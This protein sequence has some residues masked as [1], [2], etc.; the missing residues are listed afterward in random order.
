MPAQA[1]G[2]RSSEGRFEKL[3]N[4]L[5]Q[6][7]L[8][9]LV[10]QLDRFIR[11][12]RKDYQRTL[13]TWETLEAYKTT[14]PSVCDKITVDLFRSNVRI[15]MALLKSG[16]LFQGEKSQSASPHLLLGQ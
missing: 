6:G 14:V 5:A 13:A 2:C 16:R 8:E 1:N 3:F 4:A 10:I 7:P 11:A 15:G 9:S 12:T